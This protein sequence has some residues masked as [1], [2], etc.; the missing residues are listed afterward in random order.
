V[1][2][3]Q[4]LG[5]PGRL[6]ALAARLGL[7]EFTN[8]EA[9]LGV[10]WDELGR[11]ERAGELLELGELTDHPDTVATTWAL[12][13]ARAQAEAPAAQAVL[14]L[15]AFVAPDD[16]PRTLPTEHP[17]LL[18]EPLQRAA[19]DRLAYDRLIAALGRYSLLTATRD[20]LA[21]QRLVQA[22]VRATLDQPAQRRWA[23]VAVQLVWAAF[24]ADTDDPATSPA[25]ARLLPHALAATD[26]A[27][28]LAADPEATAG[29]LTR[30]GAYLWRRVEPGQARQL[31]E[32]ALAILQA[33]LGPDHPETASNL[34]NDAVAVQVEPSR[35]GER[36]SPS[37]DTPELG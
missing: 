30:V 21:V 15:C 37:T 26:H 1:A 17:Q 13:L 33:R 20:N 16:I 23:A 9:Q 7:P 14:A 29:L 27:S 18:P 28:R 2:A 35:A 36:G 19:T 24:P 34:D 11:G 25:C 22:W 5:I 4:P 12:S 10:Q 31:F 6:A 8:Q 3:E 32:P